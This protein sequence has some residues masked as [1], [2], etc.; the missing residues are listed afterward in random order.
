MIHS[1]PNINRV[2]PQLVV[3]LNRLNRH[4]AGSSLAT[5]MAVKVGRALS[6]DPINS[7]VVDFLDRG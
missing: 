4:L 5:A 6:L 3:V 2:P 1:A 7:M